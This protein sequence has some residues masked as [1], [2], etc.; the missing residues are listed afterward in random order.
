MTFRP[1]VVAVVELT[2]KRLCSYASLSFYAEFVT[3]VLT[4]ASMIV[5]FLLTSEGETKVAT[6]LRIFCAISDIRTPP[7]HCC[8][9][10]SSLVE[11]I[12]CDVD[13]SQICSMSPNSELSRHFCKVQIINFEEHS[14][15]Q[16]STR[17]L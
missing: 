15:C 3:I 9:F 17:K 2:W 4:L 12:R 6:F 10:T 7:L 11:P 16:G 14:P 1:C 8:L 5:L 13:S